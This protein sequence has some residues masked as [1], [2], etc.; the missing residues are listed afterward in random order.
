[1]LLVSAVEHYSH[2]YHRCSFLCAVGQLLNVKHE[3]LSLIPPQ[4]E[5]PLPPLQPAVFPPTLREPPPP[6]LDQF[7]LDEH[8]ASERIRLAQL[9][10]KCSESDLD[11]FVRESGEILGVQPN[12]PDDKCVSCT[13]PHASH[14]WQ[15]PQ[16]CCYLTHTPTTLFAF[17][18]CCRCPF[19]THLC[20]GVAPRTFWSTSSGSW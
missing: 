5:T 17:V 6:A 9:T 3:P 7:D 10:N 19:H 14:M 13:S 12:L 16:Q 11:Y 2:F 15:M 1:M 20:T 4:F 8:F 18:S